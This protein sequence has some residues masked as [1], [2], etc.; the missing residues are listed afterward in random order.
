MAIELIH[1]YSLVH[2]DL[3]AMDDDEIRRGSPTCHVKF[4][5][6]TAILV[7]DAL[8]SLAFQVLSDVKTHSDSE[9]RCKLINELSKSSGVSGMVGGQ[10]LDLIAS[11]KKFDINEI[12]ELQRLKTGELFHFSCIAPCILAEENEVIFKIFKKFSLN[13][14]IAFQIQDDLL[15]IEGQEDIVGKKINKDSYQGKQT[16]VS[17][18]G[19][20]DAKK[21]AKSLIDDCIKLIDCFKTK[22]ENLIKITNLIIKRNF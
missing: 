15:D 14:G 13:L 4:D 16:Y 20:E 8:Q 10:M 12:R 18:L 9:I 17:E 6:A 3:P 2:D 21:K 5:E 22:N 7:G 19:V 1:C 11:E